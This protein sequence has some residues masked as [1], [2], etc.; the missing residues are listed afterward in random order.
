MSILFLFFIS[1]NIIEITI[2]GNIQDTYFSFDRY[3]GISD[4]REKTDSSSV[5]LDLSNAEPKGV[6]VRV[7]IIDSDADRIRSNGV[8]FSGVN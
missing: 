8:T 5:Y 6:V 3:A 2:A 7:Y 1:L 4:S